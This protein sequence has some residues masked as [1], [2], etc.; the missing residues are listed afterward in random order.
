MRAELYESALAGKQQGRSLPRTQTLGRLSGKR[1]S[2]KR[3]CWCALSIVLLVVLVWRR[4]A[5]TCPASRVHCVKLPGKQ[6][7]L[8]VS[9]T[10]QRSFSTPKGNA[11]GR[12]GRKICPSGRSRRGRWPPVSGPAR[13]A[14]PFMDARRRTSSLSS[15]GPSVG[16]CFWRP[17]CCGE[18]G[19]KLLHVRSGR[20]S[21][22]FCTIRGVFGPR[23]VGSLPQ[24]L[25]AA[26]GP[27]R[28]MS[29]PPGTTGTAN[30]ASLLR[31]WRARSL[32]VPRSGQFR[33]IPRWSRV[34]NWSRA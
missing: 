18:T 1:S 2:I 12:S 31:V 5:Q 32:F 7:T 11:A 15:G 23:S 26:G 30:L 13:P 10:R 27:T 8:A 21:A 6:E 29:P 16:R 14:P 34:G 33:V 28:G 3:G 4:P 20:I 19:L 24:D 22:G 9:P 17:L 25:F